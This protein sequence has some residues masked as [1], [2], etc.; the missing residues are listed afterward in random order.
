[1]GDASQELLEQR[2]W[3]LPQ[4]VAARVHLTEP[5]THVHDSSVIYVEVQWVCFAVAAPSLQQLGSCLF[6]DLHGQKPYT[7]QTQD[8]QST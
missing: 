7:F 3:F 6:I 8:V 4:G 5:V 2:V 1:M